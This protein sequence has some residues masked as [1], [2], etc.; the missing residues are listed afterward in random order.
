MRVTIREQIEQS[1]GIARDVHFAYFLALAVVIGFIESMIP[2]LP[3]LP[4][5]RIGISH[6]IT[7]YIIITMGFRR[8]FAIS[9]LR[10]IIVAVLRGSILSGGFILGC[11]GS[12]IA[13]CCMGII[14]LLRNNVSAVGISVTGAVTFNIM[15]L[16]LAR[17]ILGLAP[18]I[19][20][21]MPLLILIGTGTGIIT[22]IITQWLLLL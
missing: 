10:L 18:L 22:G 21:L 3:V 19:F 7:V 5:L 13:V 1:N 14:S 2:I 15:Q 9:L 12:I 11:G 6:A 20:E 4:W 8:A 17:Y 16:L